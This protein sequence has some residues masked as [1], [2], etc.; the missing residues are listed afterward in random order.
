MI[1]GHFQLSPTIRP[2]IVSELV[3]N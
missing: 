3:G 2:S 1:A